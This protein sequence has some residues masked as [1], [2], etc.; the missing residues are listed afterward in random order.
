MRV[1][2]VSS[3]P[4]NPDDTLGST[5]ELSQ[6]KLLSKLYDVA[7]LSVSEAVPIKQ[8]LGAALKRR[9]AEP[10]GGYLKGLFQTGADFFKHVFGYREVRI[11]VIEGIAV[12]EGISSRLTSETEFSA[13]LKNWLAAARAAF[14]KYREARGSPDL[15]HAHGRFLKAGVFALEN[16][17]AARIPYIYTEHSSFFQRGWAP[18]IAQQTLLD[19]IRGAAVYS[20]VSRSL[21][22]SVE[23]FLGTAVRKPEILPNVVDPAFERNPADFPSAPPFVFIQVA[24]LDV[25][26]GVDLLLRAFAKAFGT[27]PAC[28]LTICGDGPMRSELQALAESL[29][30]SSAVRFA[31]K[32]TKDDVRR[33]IDNAHALVLSSRIET[34]GV[35]LIEAL[36]R[37]RPVIATRCG[38]PEDIVEA[39][40]GILVDC[41]NV[42]Q[43]ADAL[44]RMTRDAATYD[45]DGIRQVALRR[46]GAAAF[47]ER[48]QP[49]YQHAL[50]GG[51]VTLSA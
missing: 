50:A 22:K 6:A 12:Y 28:T 7:I 47:L 41:D 25:N 40:N 9:L 34:F 51:V 24:S 42:P 27:G 44:Q 14:L 20:A 3:E 36:A 1:L 33:Q 38:G 15:V 8:R 2:V 29:G 49:I 26:K 31:G 23:A 4:L 46:Y 13:E 21:A 39:H 10:S 43:L 48:M 18:K 30:I 11:H 45:R 17:K 16:R 37:G 35:V 5:F 19:V 32:L